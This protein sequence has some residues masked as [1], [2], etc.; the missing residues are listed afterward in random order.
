MS[1][2]KNS[3]KPEENILATSAASAD[4]E[5]MTIHDDT[6]SMMNAM[7]AAI[8]EAEAAK[9]AKAA[10]IDEALKPLIPSKKQAAEERAK[11]PQKPKPVKRT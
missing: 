1:N 8:D 7:Q 5:G 10:K 3:P 4:L 2:K 9:I 11:K 6:V